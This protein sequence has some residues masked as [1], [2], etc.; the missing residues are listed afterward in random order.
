M[1]G[2]KNRVAPGDPGDDDQPQ[3]V[4][5]IDGEQNGEGQEERLWGFDVDVLQGCPQGVQGDHVD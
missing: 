5:G 1:V 4:D 2:M 3:E